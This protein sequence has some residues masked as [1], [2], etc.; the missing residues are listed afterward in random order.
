MW[1][2]TW[3]AFVF[4]ERVRPRRVCKRKVEVYLSSVGGKTCFLT[5]PPNLCVPSFRL[6]RCPGPWT[7]ITRPPQLLDQLYALK[8]QIYY[9][10]YPMKIYYISDPT[11]EPADYAEKVRFFFVFLVIFDAP[12][13]PGCRCLALEKPH[14]GG[15]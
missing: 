13:P 6:M 4:C 8:D 5:P 15:L 9:L 14:P 10:S 12:T 3:R 2:R 7:R 11:A 1:R